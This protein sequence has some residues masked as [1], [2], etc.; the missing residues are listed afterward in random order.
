VSTGN[1]SDLAI[2]KRLLLEA[3]PFWPHIG[4]IFALDLLATPLAL[5]TPIPLM[6]A[7]DSVI[8]SEPLPQLVQAMAPELVTSSPGPMLGFVVV[9]VVVIALLTQ[10]QK[11]GGW[12]L[13][14]YA[15]EQLAMRFR[16]RLLR[17]AQ[18]LSLA[19]HDARGTADS[20][21][22]VQYDAPAIQWVVIY[23]IT[24]FITASLT[25]VAMIYVTA[26]IDW[27]L[28]L[29]A[30]A[31]SPVL[32]FLTNI[33]RKRLRSQWREV[34]K[35]EMSALS[36]VQEVLGALR[37]IK[38]FGQEEREQGRFLRRSHEG[39]GARIR[40]V[41]R[42]SAFNLS[43]GL[44]VAVGTAAVLF[45]GV[46]HVGAGVL[47]LGQL[48]LVMSYLAQ[49][50]QPL[51]TLGQQVAK[52]QGGLASAER[53]FALLDES[54]DVPERPDARP[55]KRAAGKLEY[56]DVS[57]SYDGATAVL[58]SISF[59]IPAG[60]RVGIMGRTGA[61][62]TTLVNLLMRFYDPTAGQ[63]LLD[64]VDIRN[65]R[66]ADLRDQFAIVL[67]EPVLLHT[68]IAENIAY[69]RPSASES[70]IE[71]AA[72]AANADEFIRKLPQGYNTPVGER[73]L[74]LSGGQRQR[75]A[76]ARAFLKDAPI[77]ILDEP[78]SSVDL[79]T[80]AAI[81]EAMERLMLGRTVVMIAHR[82]TTLENLDMTLALDHG[83]LVQVFDSGAQTLA[84]AFH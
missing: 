52:L 55:L 35:L 80:E 81:M 71:W 15:G 54:H 10:G 11:L 78:T 8:G 67:Q 57:F 18:R 27:Q 74:S 76:L 69:G 44:T 51:Q 77:L 25:L 66:L 50:Y 84:A 31:V 13:Q 14:T 7:V 2:L 36:V 65:Y 49:L 34:K 46:Q 43:V 23:G 58:D 28:A 79:K 32:L 37:V 6:L 56:R 40:V 3:R 19:Y 26:R 38:A 75:I 41:L 53:A 72:K 16:G 70:E 48:L 29:V 9:L 5:L 82:L 22:R 4:G 42:E 17:H 12:L 83:R 63:V 20:I 64:G 59:S 33:F 45:V 61:G 68:T 24:P 21:Y 60:S 30:L 39:V 1:R 47:T 62:K 73:G